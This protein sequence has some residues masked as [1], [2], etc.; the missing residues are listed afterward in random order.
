MLQDFITANRARI[1]ELAQQRVRERTA[2]KTTEGGTELGIPA[3][4]S[5]LIDALE[6]NALTG[7]RSNE[8]DNVGI[9]GTAAHYGYELLKS[10]F[11]VA[12]VVHGYGDVCQIV[13]ELAT[14]TDAAISPDDFRV[15]NRCLD[16]AIAGAVT[17]FQDQREAE[18][19]YEG[20]ERLGVLA[21]EMRNLLNT[22]TLSFEVLTKGVVGI[23]GST[24]AIHSRALAELRLLVDRSLMEVRL[25]AGVPKLER[26]SLAEFIEPIHAAAAMQAEAH[27]HLFSVGPIERNVAMD[28]D[29]QLLRG[30]LANLL[31]NAFKFSKVPGNVVLTARVTQERIALEVADSCGGLPPG[32]ADGI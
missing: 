27:H 13:T 17:A 30:A 24:G 2:L 16:D 1:I 12:Q 20:T 25:E 32:E 3:F 31:Q 21:H 7:S 23:R 11:T 6:L 22:A 4:L 14:Q 8:P 18:L 29:R 28:V 26:T 9:R 5:Q 10:G 19:A 15:F